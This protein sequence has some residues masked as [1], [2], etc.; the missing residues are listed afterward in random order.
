MGPIQTALGQ[1][2]GSVGAA[3][4]VGKKLYEGQAAEK[5]RASAAEAKEAEKEA[6]KNQ[7]QAQADD[8]QIEKLASEY[9][10]ARGKGEKIDEKAIDIATKALR[11]AQQ[12]K[13]DSPKQVFFWEDESSPLGTSN[14][15]A[16]VLS[17]QS[18]HN[19]LSS[20]KRTKANIEARR[21]RAKAK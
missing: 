1:A 21:A 6:K 19:S 17:S 10:K 8:K 9:L 11:A 16:T 5:E 13:I 15:I 7:K 18:L 14:E 2:L 12:S 4:L 3:G 20:K